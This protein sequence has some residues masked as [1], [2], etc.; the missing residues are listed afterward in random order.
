[1]KASILDTLERATEVVGLV[2]V[3]FCSITYLVLAWWP[4]VT[5][6]D[7]LAVPLEPLDGPAV[8]LLAGTLV[9]GIIRCLIGRARRRAEEEAP[10]GSGAAHSGPGAVDSRSG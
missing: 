9:A 1:M 6:R 10:T 8:A 3:L 5:P 7:N 4:V 2:W